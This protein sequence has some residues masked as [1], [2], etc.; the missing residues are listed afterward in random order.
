MVMMYKNVPWI[1]ET[2]DYSAR[3]FYVPNNVDIYPKIEDD[4]KFAAD[5]LNE[6]KS[7]AGRLNKWAAKAF[8]AKTYLFQKKFTE[9]KPILDDIILNGVTAR[10]Q[11]YGL[12][13]AYG[14]N[15]KTAG[16]NSKESVFAAQMSVNDGANGANGNPGEYYNGSFGGPA[17]C[18]YGWTQPTFDFVDRFQTDA[19]TGLPLLDTYHLTPIPHDQNLTS[20]DPFTPYAGTLDPRLDWSVGRRGIPYLDWGVMPG[21]AW[22]RNQ[23]LCGPYLS[24]KH[25][26]TQANVNSD[27]ERG[28]ATNTPY[29]LIRFADVL[30]W[31]AECEVEVGSLGKA[32]E[33]VNQVRARAGDPKSFVYKYLDDSKPTGGY[34][35]EPAANYKVNTYPV[36]TF[37][38]NGKTFARKAVRYERK[39]ELALEWHNL[40]DMRRWDGNEFDLQVALDTY[41]GREAA[42]PYA[43]TTNY[44]TAK[45]TRNKHELY[46]IPQDQIDLMVEVKGGASALTQNPGYN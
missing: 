38:A 6:V 27:R 33:Y 13:D 39:L 46:P 7:Q 10:N 45:F 30:L 31:A 17:T 11:K 43:P 37:A 16:K 28:F 9:A 41:W 42:R 40:F 5:N 29:D 18:C 26:A 24:M 20:N 34:S 19:V 14:D 4:F 2:I 36:G 1:D 12:Q 25:L 22:V 32:E 23:Y 35:T 3:N 21:K 44:K 15:F 8:L